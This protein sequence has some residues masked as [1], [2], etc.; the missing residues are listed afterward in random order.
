MI[1]TNAGQP[2]LDFQSW[3]L[4]NGFEGIFTQYSTKHCR[5]TNTTASI[6]VRRIIPGGYFIFSGSFAK[7]LEQKEVIVVCVLCSFA[8]QNTPPALIQS[9]GT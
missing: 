1:V 2:G 3:I 4:Y 6:E 9:K 7:F 5:W 8:A